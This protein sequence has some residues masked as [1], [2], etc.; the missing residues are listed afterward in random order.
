MCIHV[1][2]MAALFGSCLALPRGGLASLPS[3]GIALDRVSLSLPCSLDVST[4]VPD[5]EHV[6]GYS[7]GAGERRGLYTGSST[8]RSLSGWSPSGKQAVGEGICCVMA[9]AA[10]GTPI[11]VNESK[12]STYIYLSGG[13]LYSPE[14]SPMVSIYLSTVPVSNMLICYYLPVC[15]TSYYW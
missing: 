4:H 2:R 6:S 9:Q 10:D 5:I 11:L 12:P 8:L 13:Y 3:S 14:S 15:S 1:G 7:T